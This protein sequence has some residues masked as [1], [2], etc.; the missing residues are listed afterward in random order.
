MPTRSLA[1]LV[2]ALVALTGCTG[3]DLLGTSPSTGPATA[4]SA[5][6]SPSTPPSASASAP[7]SPSPSES[8]D[9]PSLTPL[10]VLVSGEAGARYAGLYAAT[11]A[12]GYRRACLDVTVGYAS[13]P[14]PLSS[15]PASPQVA[16]WTVPEG[17]A[18]REEGADVTDV[19]QVFQRSGLRQ[20]SWATDPLAS[21]ADF[22]DARVG[23]SPDGGFEVIAAVS[24]AGLDPVADVTLQSPGGYR[25]LLAGDVQ[26]SA[27]QS[28]DGYVRLLGSIRPGTESPITPADIAVVDY[29]QLGWG[30]LPDGI[31]ANG[32]GLTDAGYRDVVQRFVTATLR[33]WIT[34][35]DDPDAC[36][37]AL[38]AAVP[39]DDVTLQQQMVDEV[40]ALIWPSAAG[41]GSVDAAQW[42]RTVAIGLATK[43]LTGERFITAPPTAGAH[44]DELASAARDAIATEGLSTSG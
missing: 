33:G 10:T 27:V 28:Y 2:T 29:Q 36:T 22:R 25:A 13:E 35:R 37:E 34:C 15:D 7:P 6:A 43:A 44:S 41:I 8:T 38:H 40:N 4:A 17:L 11:Q 20:V 42:D 32:A 31:W 30:L 18:T 16:I 12:G 14:G 3:T 24:A 9:C 5:S 19:A 23:L 1:L 26:A 39:D 21:P